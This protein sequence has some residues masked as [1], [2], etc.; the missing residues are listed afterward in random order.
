MSSPSS[1]ASRASACG[2]IAPPMSIF[3]PE[4]GMPF[5]LHPQD[6]WHA[7]RNG[8]FFAL[9]ECNDRVG[10]VASAIN[11]LYAQHGGDVR[12]APGVN[13]EHRRYGHVDVFIFEQTLAHCCQ[14]GTGR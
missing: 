5:A 2:R 3:Q 7:V 1:S 6:G 14:G 8:H 9:K 11:L 12:E 10:C 4:R 13:M